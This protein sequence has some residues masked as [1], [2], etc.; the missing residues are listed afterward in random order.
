MS[1][2]GEMVGKGAEREEGGG[3]RERWS[4]KED[5]CHGERGVTLP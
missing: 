3:R 5:D 4:H 2:G 1:G